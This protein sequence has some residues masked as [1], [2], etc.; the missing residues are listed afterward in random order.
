M[1]LPVLVGRM[2]NQMFQIACCIGMAK[3]HGLQYHVP[4][5]TQNDGLWI[6]RFLHLQNENYNPYIPLTVIKESSFEYH[7]I[8]FEEK[9]KLR[10]TE[11][12]GYWQSEKYFNHCKEEVKE[13]FNIPYKKQEGFVSLHVRRTDYL[14][15]PNHH[16]VITNEY[17][18][19]AQRR[20]MNEGYYKFI[21]F[22]DDPVWNKEHINKEIYPLGDFE[23]SE[24]KTEKEDL[25]LMSSCEHNICSN[26]TYAWWGAWLNQNPN[27]IVIMPKRWFGPAC[28]HNTS[29]LYPP[30]TIIL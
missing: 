19:E 3:K 17:I 30:K 22:G 26:S 15:F 11:L 9:W 12:R 14:T 4:A 10:N 21:V 6:P 28:N 29:D 20:L 8:P 7:E 18:E 2:C 27:K 13:A 16:P 23:Y 24:G 5:H 1:F 25:S